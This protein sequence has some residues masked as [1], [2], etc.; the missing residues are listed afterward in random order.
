[1]K[2]R[3]LIT[4][5]LFGLGFAPAAFAQTR[6]TSA[7]DFVQKAAISNTFEIQSSQ[8]AV[9][10]ARSDGVKNFA[11]RMIDDHSRALE[12]LQEVAKASNLQA[13]PS[14]DA[15]HQK[16]VDELKAIPDS[17]FDNRYISM[18]TTAHEKA[19]QLFSDYS[20]RG[21]DPQLKAFAAEILPTLQEHLK[22]VQQLKGTM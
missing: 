12:R 5:V 18:Q 16:M 13:A 6:S 9:D 22:E 20:Q 21:T 3:A 17:N 1:M 14:M 7:Q 4:V 15:E 19:V 8:V 2:W 11:Q 10:R